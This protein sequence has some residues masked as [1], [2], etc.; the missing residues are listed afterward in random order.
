MNDAWQDFRYLEAIA[1]VAILKSVFISEIGLQLSG[2]VSPL[3]FFGIRVITCTHVFDASLAETRR[4]ILR[5]HFDVDPKWV[6][7]VAMRKQLM[8]NG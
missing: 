4:I 7:W 2:S 6:S 3:I 8:C 1:L 5:F